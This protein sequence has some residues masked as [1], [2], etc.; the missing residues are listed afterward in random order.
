[1]SNKEPDRC[2]SWTILVYH[3]LIGRCIC[4]TD[5]K[6]LVSNFN[7]EKD[8]W[9]L[10]MKFPINLKFIVKVNNILPPSA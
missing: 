9:N 7:A 1:M 3:R 4:C 10:S 8:V 5:M 2:N 6:T